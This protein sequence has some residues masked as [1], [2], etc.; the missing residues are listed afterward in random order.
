MYCSRNDIGR[1]D[2]CGGECGEKLLPKI[3]SNAS[4]LVAADRTDGTLDGAFVRNGLGEEIAV[5]LKPPP[6]DDNPSKSCC[7]CRCCCCC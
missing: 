7:T 4:S 6:S 1:L 2:C 5:S 3:S